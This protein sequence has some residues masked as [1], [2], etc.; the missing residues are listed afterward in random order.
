MVTIRKNLVTSKDMIYDGVNPCTS[1][2]VH[3]TDNESIGADADAHGRLQADGNVRQASWHYTVDDKEAVQSYP[4]TAQCWH[5]GTTEG[6]KTSIAVE[7]CVNADG[8][9]DKAVSNAAELVADLLKAHHLTID[10]VVQ[11]HHWSGKNCPSRMR[12]T[13]KWDAFIQQV[14]QHTKEGHP[15]SHMV[16]PFKGRVTAEWRGYTN[17]A[18]IDIAPPKPGQTGLPVYAAFAGTIKAINRTAKPGNRTSTWAPY[19]TGRGMLIANPDGEGNGYNHI[20]PLASLQ[21]GDKVKAGD[22]IGHN[23]TSGNQTGPH[24]HFEMWANWRDPSSDYN[25]RLAFNKFGVAPGSAPDI[26]VKPGASK[27]KPAPKPKPT[28]KPSKVKNAHLTNEEAERVQRALKS[29]GY[30]KGDID[31]KPYGLTEDAIKHYQQAQLFGGLVADGVWGT[32]T[33]AHYH[34]VK[35]LQNAM[36]E[37]KGTKLVIDGDYRAITRN[38]VKDIMERNQ[39]K[40]YKGYPDGVPGPIFCQMLGIPTHP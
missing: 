25:P 27:P 5:A 21:V 18:G 16:S 28:A 30:Y 36:N 22:L 37:W 14:K 6:C 31:G 3:E 12:A 11:H 32:K 23:D 26:D 33:Q 35:T 13:G 24:L 40:A 2:T 20:T 38:R 34:W 17:H 4:D 15:V 39:G 1:I 10:V 8:D 9:Y 29:M 19:R 7:I